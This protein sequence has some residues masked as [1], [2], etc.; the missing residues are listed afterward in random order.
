M[1]R[2]LGLAALIALVPLAVVAGDGTAD[3]PAGVA[4]P[5]DRD[6]LFGHDDL[7]LGIDR[8]VVKVG[9]ELGKF[10]RIRLRVVGNDVHV[11]TLRIVYEDRSH[12]D[13]TVDADIKTNT[14]SGWFDIDGA[15]FIHEIQMTYR[16]R[17]GLKGPTRI[18]VT[19]EYAKGWLAAEGEGR[20]YHQGWVL[21]GA[22]I[23]GFTGFD[24]DVI[25][26]GENEGFKRLRIEALD[27][28]ITLKEIRVKFATGPDE[29]FAMRERIDP[30]KPYGPLEFK[31][32]KAP[33]KSIVA[34]YRSRFDL[35][36]G[37]KSALDGR[38]AVVQI[39][40]QH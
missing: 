22:Q 1:L 16:A 10:N 40:G 29:V 2:S 25:A 35:Q 17:P 14:Q 30:G 39:W 13:F 37:L 31:S 28:A 21:L 23:A 27:R 15:K 7:E 26:V 32:G 9:G 24:R 5:D 6:I 12:R 38:P 20:N 33:I 36:K 8:E 34:L 4:A 18:E 19:G 3:T 11:Q